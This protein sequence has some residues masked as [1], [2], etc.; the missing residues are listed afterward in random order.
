[1]GPP[2]PPLLSHA[3]DPE[4]AVNRPV[5][6]RQTQ[7]WLA[8]AVGV[9]LVGLGLMAAWIFRSRP[10]PLS[11]PVQPE[12]GP[13]WVQFGKEV[14]QDGLV[15]VAQQHDG[16]TEPSLAGGLECHALRKSPG[17]AELYAYFR[18]DPPL[19]E[20]PTKFII[21][22]IEYFDADAV[23]QFRIDYDSLDQSKKL[24]S[25]YWQ[26]KELVKLKGTQRWRKARFLIDDARFEG[27]QNDRADF[28][29]SVTGSRFF[30][31]SVKVLQE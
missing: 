15:S 7:W 16:A 11:R 5:R 29:V 30:L 4:L 25:A 9:M 6:S 12:A 3:P 19:Q 22:E 17:V 20:V 14:K 8:L 27:R 24:I 23:G 31:R 28:R 2:K 26:S 21:I 10:M 1:M 13:S 18:F